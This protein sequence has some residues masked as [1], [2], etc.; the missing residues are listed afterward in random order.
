MQEETTTNGMRYKWCLAGPQGAGFVVFIDNHTTEELKEAIREIRR[1]Q[2][3]VWIRQANKEDLIEDY[4]QKVFRYADTTY[5]LSW[6]QIDYDIPE[7]SNAM[8]TGKTPEQY[9]DSK[10]KIWK[11]PKISK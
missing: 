5:Y 9:V 1:E 2:D 6:K 4:W 8:R 10:W 11:S 3:V 7:L